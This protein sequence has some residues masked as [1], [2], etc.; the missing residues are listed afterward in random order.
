MKNNNKFTQNITIAAK[1]IGFKYCY[2]LIKNESLIN[3][4][5]ELGFIKGSKYSIELIKSL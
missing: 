2:S 3:A 4:Y 5:Q 1:D